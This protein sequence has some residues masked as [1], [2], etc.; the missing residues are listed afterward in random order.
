MRNPPASE[1]FNEEICNLVKRRIQ[2]SLSRLDELTIAF[3]YEGDVTG[4][5]ST[6]ILQ[7]TSKIYARALD[8]SRSSDS[9]ERAEALRLFAANL[10][11]AFYGFEPDFFHQNLVRVVDDVI[12]VIK[13]SIELW[14]T[15]V[16]ICYFQKVRKGLPQLR[17]ANQAA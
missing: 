9:P 14:P 10:H 15:L 7:K 3:D 12:G 2:G 5:D 6:Q 8:A 11:K 17:V 13:G 1:V 16:E 4:N